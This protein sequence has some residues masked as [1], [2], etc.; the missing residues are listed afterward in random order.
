MSLKLH[1]T[2]SSCGRLALFGSVNVYMRLALLS[3]ADT[4]KI[5]HYLSLCLH[6][7]LSHYSSIPFLH[8][9]EIHFQPLIN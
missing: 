3:E 4:A 7:T 9:A 1:A 5:F 8:T 2:P 6:L